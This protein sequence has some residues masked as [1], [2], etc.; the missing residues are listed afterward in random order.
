MDRIIFHSISESGGRIRSRWT[1]WAAGAIVA[2]GAQ[3]ALMGA[4]A[5]QATTAPS[6]SINVHVELTDSGVKLTPPHGYPVAEAGYVTLFR[7]YNKSSDSRRFIAATSSVVV[8][9]GS[10]A[11]FYVFFPTVVHGAQLQWRSTALSGAGKNDFQGRFAV[12]PCRT[13]ACLDQG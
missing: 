4:P 3:F 12:K 9:K 7:V 2:A 5:A 1:L 6:N 10:N 13:L 11:G 8:K